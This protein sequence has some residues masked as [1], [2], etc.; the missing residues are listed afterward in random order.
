MRSDV[1]SLNRTTTRPKNPSSYTRSDIQ[2]GFTTI[3]QSTK[4]EFDSTTTIV[5]SEIF[6][7]HGS[8]SSHKSLVPYFAGKGRFSTKYKEIVKRMHSWTNEDDFLANSSSIS[9]V[10]NEENQDT[11]R[12]WTRHATHKIYKLDFWLMQCLIHGTTAWN[13]FIFIFNPSTSTWGIIV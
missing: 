2:T 4:D 5:N 1:S 7:E 9:S 13:W 3:L 12:R 11:S 8:R 6:N 10:S